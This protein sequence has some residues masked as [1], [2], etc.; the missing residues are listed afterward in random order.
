VNEWFVDGAGRLELPFGSV[1]RPIEAM[2]IQGVS[3][4]PEVDQGANLAL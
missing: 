3:E 1:E 2:R 4:G